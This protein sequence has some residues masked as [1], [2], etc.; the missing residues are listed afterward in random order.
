MEGEITSVT[1]FGAFVK[2]RDEIEGLIHFKDYSWDDRID[3]KML[4][5]GDRVSYRI[6]DVN[7]REKRISCGIKQL[8]E[9]PYEELRRK[10]RKGEILECTITGITDFGI[11]V[12]IGDGHEGLIHIS[13]IPLEEGQKLDELFH[14]GD[15]LHASLIKIEPDEK[16]IA[17]S[18]KDVEKRR[19][20]EI[21]SKY[22]KRDDTPS[23]SSLGNFMKSE[24]K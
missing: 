8:A 13:R 23:T 16:R 3:H 9:N 4:K 20:R 7:T 6:L 2:I 17:L 10:Y 1:K 19:E 22:I 11:F 12:D 14:K 5:K 15:K 24:E 18:I 21:I